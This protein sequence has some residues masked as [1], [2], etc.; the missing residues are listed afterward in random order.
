MTVDERVSG[1][2]PGYLGWVEVSGERLRE[3]KLTLGDYAQ[4]LRFDDV[5]SERYSQRTDRGFLELMNHSN[6]QGY[7][8]F[9]GSNQETASDR[10]LSEMGNRQI[11]IYGEV[12]EARDTTFV[13]WQLRGAA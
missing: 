11:L 9:T 2:Q 10:F 6:T 1:E 13:R 12:G 5:D 7:A 4:S 3:L 8:F